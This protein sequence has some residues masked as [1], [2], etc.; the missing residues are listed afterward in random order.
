MEDTKIQSEKSK[1]KL[2]TIERFNFCSK[3]SFA[4][5]VESRKYVIK[6]TYFSGQRWLFRVERQAEGGLKRHRAARRRAIL[7]SAKVA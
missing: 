6:Q 1:I 7:A 2:K 4:M 3:H 5:L